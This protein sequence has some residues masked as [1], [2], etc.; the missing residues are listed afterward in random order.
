MNII[1][2]RGFWKAL[3]EKN[4]LIAF[5]R[6]LVNGFGIE[7]DFRDFNGEIII[8]HDVPRVMGLS[9][10]KFFRLV[11]Q[12]NPSAII[13]VNIKSD[14]LKSMFDASW[15]EHPEKLFFFDMSTPDMVS[16]LDSPY[17]VYTRHSEIEKIPVF[18]EKSS[19]VWLDSFGLEW[20]GRD[21]IDTHLS[22]GKRLCIVSPELHGRDHTT[23]WASL[24]LWGLYK[25][26]NVSLCTDFPGMA[27]EYFNG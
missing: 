4:Q 14:C 24:K 1:A 26:G 3:S 22:N 6:A 21:V 12:I 10:I 16:Y 20:Y 13:A 19:G 11:R 5:E 9:A 23:L 15:S 2:H 7:T 27:K 17:H 25:N 18:Y 8:S